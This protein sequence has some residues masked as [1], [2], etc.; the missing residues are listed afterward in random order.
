MRQGHPRDSNAGNAVLWLLAICALGAAVYFLLMK[1]PE[2]QPVTSE[3]V[4][5]VPPT[6]SATPAPAIAEAT[7][8]PEPEPTAAPR[9]VVVATPTPAEETLTNEIIERTPALWPKQVAL[10]RPEKMN[11]VFNGR[12]A[13]QVQVPGGTA[14]RVLRV[15]GSQVEVEYQNSRQMIP[16]ASTDLMSRALAAR[17]TSGGSQ[18]AQVS[19]P[20][21]VSA[22]PPISAAPIARGEPNPTRLSAEVVRLKKSRIQG[23]DWDDKT[24]SITL[25]VKL[26]NGDPGGALDGLTGDIYVFAESILDRSVL[27]L[28]LAKSFRCSIPPHGTHEFVTD[29]VKTRYDTTDAR[30]GFKYEGWLLRVKSSSGKVLLEKATSPSLV[31]NAERISTLSADRDYDRKDFSAAKTATTGGL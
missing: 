11:I 3:V 9:P 25:K 27:R 4:P 14:L 26:E 2:P 17:R 18:P 22:P 10:S 16:A 21:S 28:L 29:E 24:D 1:K 7:P 23:G 13:G 12:V 30:F 15:A 8:P 31:K 19:A 20:A 6:P 5:A